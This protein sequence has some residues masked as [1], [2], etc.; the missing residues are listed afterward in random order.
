MLLAIYYIMLILTWLKLEPEYIIYL[1]I[2]Y[3]TIAL[4]F[5]VLVLFSRYNKWLDKAGR[6]VFYY[7]IISFIIPM[8]GFIA[9]TLE[10][11]FWI[12]NIVYVLQFLTLSGFYFQIIK[13]ILFKRLIVVLTLLAF[14]VFCLDYC[15]WE[16]PMKYNEIFGMVRISLLIIYGVVFM[17]QVMSD[18]ELITKG[19]SA[20]SLPNFW[21]NAGTF[22]FY[23]GVFLPMVS[24]YLLFDSPFYFT[25]TNT[26]VLVGGSIEFI[27]Y[28]VG[29]RKV[30]QQARRKLRA[31]E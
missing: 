13:K 17:L 11:C 2:Y 1:A 7:V 14:V 20:Q 16:G 10:D 31:S 15:W 8:L 5:L 30:K 24:A 18:Q 12:L 4:G 27:L 28:Y 26:L 19:I 21:F 6:Y 22:I 3:T 9:Q 29:V 25:L 23:T